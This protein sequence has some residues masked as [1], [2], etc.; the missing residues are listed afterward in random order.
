MQLPVELEG[1]EVL[2][3]KTA[4]SLA[5]TASNGQ[6]VSGAMKESAR[7]AKDR[8][9]EHSERIDEA[10]DGVAVLIDTGLWGTGPFSIALSGTE[11]SFYLSIKG[12]NG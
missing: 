7:I 5:A 11:D 2:G 3:L 1:Y 4:W 8:T 9:P 12:N 6:S 10:V